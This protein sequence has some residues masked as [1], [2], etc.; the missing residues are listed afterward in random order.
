MHNQTHEPT[1]LHYGT[2]THLTQPTYP[3]TALSP[4]NVPTKMDSLLYHHLIQRLVPR[5]NA[6]NGYTVP[7]D[8]PTNTPPA[9]AP[10][11]RTHYYPLLA[12]QRLKYC[13]YFLPH[14]I[15]S[16]IKQPTDFLPTNTVPSLIH[17]T[18]L[19]PNPTN[20]NTHSISHRFIHRRQHMQSHPH[21]ISPTTCDDDDVGTTH[22]FEHTV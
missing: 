1:T 3:P 8:S 9:N 5:T 10:T 18:N 12:R 16:P 17:T 15:V 19:T 7:T 21:Y 22:T 14:F 11:Q 2:N 4:T 13:R 20:G 6:L